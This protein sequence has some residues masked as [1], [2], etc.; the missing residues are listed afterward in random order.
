M[1]EPVRFY[2]DEDTISRALISFLRARNVD[3]L[4]AHEA[5][6]ISVPDGQHLEY[7]ANLNRVIFTFSTRDFSF[8]HKE[9][10]AVERHHAGIVV[11]DQGQVGLL[12]R[13]LLKLAD[14]LSAEEMQD[15][16]EFLGN[17]P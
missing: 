2:L 13:R 16:L 5:G 12:A 6:M 10:L 3:I 4:S 14:T 17:W 15:R 1:P 9:W 7:A 11:S 8:L